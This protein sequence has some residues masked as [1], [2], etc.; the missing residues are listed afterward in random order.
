VRGGLDEVI[1]AVAARIVALWDE[2]ASELNDQVID[3][4]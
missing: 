2:D 1:D 4:S 3:L